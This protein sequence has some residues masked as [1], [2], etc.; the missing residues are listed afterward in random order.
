MRAVV[1]RLE[2]ADELAEAV[3]WYQRRRLGLGDELLL[4]VEAAIGQI[5]RS[6]EMYPVVY[7]DVRRLLT[8]RFPYGI[9]YRLEP[10]RVVVVAIFHGRRDPRAV[11]ARH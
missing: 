2:A 8:R 5:L 7:R 6:P 4:V 10:E 1:L 9:Y 11:Q 3:Q